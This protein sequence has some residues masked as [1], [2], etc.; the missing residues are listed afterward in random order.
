MNFHLLKQSNKTSFQ[1]QIQDSGKGVHVY[2][3]VGG[4]LCCFS[5]IF[6]KYPMR[7]QGFSWIEIYFGHFVQAAPIFFGHLEFFRTFFNTHFY[8]H[9]RKLPSTFSN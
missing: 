4:S 6:L 5:L 9:K 3:G 2:K 1:G 8:H 7:M